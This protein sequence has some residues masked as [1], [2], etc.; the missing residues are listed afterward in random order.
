LGCNRGARSG[1]EDL[2]GLAADDGPDLLGVGDLAAVEEGGDLVEEL[3]RRLGADVGGEQDL[4]DLLLEEAADAGLA[5]EQGGEAG[6]EAAAGAGEAELVAAAL[7]EAGL[8]DDD[9]GAAARAACPAAAGRWSRSRGGDRLDWDRP[10]DRAEPG[11][12]RRAAP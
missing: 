11:R 9:G 6:D 12:A 3:L 8:V 4:L 10:R 5:A 7:G 2:A 1:G